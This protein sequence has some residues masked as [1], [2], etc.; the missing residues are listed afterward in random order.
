LE[1]RD[2]HRDD[3]G[4]AMAEKRI[5][6]L[7]E[8]VSK[9]AAR[10]AELQRE[11]ETLASDLVKELGDDKPPVWA[12]IKAEGGARQLGPHMIMQDKWVRGDLVFEVTP[13]QKFVVGLQIREA[14]HG[15]HEVCV[16][17]E[18]SRAL[19][20]D[21]PDEKDRAEARKKLFDQVFEYLE[22]KVRESVAFPA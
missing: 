16:H 9:A 17:N 3:E 18:P 22:R 12:E 14:G 5:D 19:T 13:E 6:D 1:I 2:R 11:L 21:P 10:D 4:H 8:I 20:I 7:R 15:K